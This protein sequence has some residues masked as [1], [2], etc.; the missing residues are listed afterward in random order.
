[1]L[2]R[3]LPADRLHVGHRLI[4]L[5]DHGEHIEARFEKGVRISTEILVSADGIHS[6]VRRPLFG[7]EK[8][9]CA[10]YRGLIP[11]ERLD[12]LNL[13][14]TSEFRRFDFTSRLGAL[15]A[16]TSEIASL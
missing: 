13:D 16:Q 12:R 11:A 8:P 9:R 4:D 3:A 1:M 5:A 10:A 15:R 2:V 6:T 7:P 14:V